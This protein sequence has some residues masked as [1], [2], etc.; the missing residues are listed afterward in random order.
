[1]LTL[2]VIHQAD[3]VTLFQ[4]G[5]AVLYER[6][7]QLDETS[8]GTLFLESHCSSTCSKSCASLRPICP[9]SDT[10]SIGC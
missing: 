3:L 5:L 7:L 1:M 9:V 10:R 4:W 8:Y 6:P 2:G